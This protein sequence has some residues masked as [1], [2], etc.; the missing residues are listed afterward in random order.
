M[1]WER[2]LGPVEKNATLEEKNKK[3]KGGAEPRV[4]VGKSPRRNS[5]EEILN[6]LIIMAIEMQSWERE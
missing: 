4:G 3:K 6:M 1:T 2:G 5:G